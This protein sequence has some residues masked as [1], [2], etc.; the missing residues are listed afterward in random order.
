VPFPLK[1]SAWTARFSV[2][3]LTLRSDKRQLRAL[4]SADG[5]APCLARKDICISCAALC[6][7][8]RPTTRASGGRTVRIEIPYCGTSET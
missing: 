6:G 1:T 2:K 4:D 5:Q 7:A 3:G 8:P